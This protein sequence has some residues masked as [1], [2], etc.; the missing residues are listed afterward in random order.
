M[1]APLRTDYY[2]LYITRAAVRI[3]VCR[4]FRLYKGQRA[5]GN[6]TEVESTELLLYYIP[7]HRY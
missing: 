4:D 1:S 6:R 5:A 7:T 3:L 2:L